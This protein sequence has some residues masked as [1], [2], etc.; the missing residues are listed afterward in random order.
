MVH[1]ITQGVRLSSLFPRARR[2]GSPDVLVSSC[3]SEAAHVRP[4][5]IYVALVRA[6]RDGHEEIS[7]AIRRGAVA[8]VVERPL[9]IGIPQYVVDDTREALG[10]ICQHL[11][12][13]PAQR[14]RTIGVSGTHGKTCVSLLL[15]SI[16]KATGVATGTSHS[17][18][19]SDSLRR[20]PTSLTTPPAPELARR[21]ADMEAA[22][23]VAAVL[24]VNSQALA[25]RR[26][27]SIGWDVAVLTNLRRAHLDWH[28]T[29][30][31]Y[32]RAKMR[33]FE[34]LKEDGTAV[35]NADDPASRFVRSE[36][37]CPVMTFGIREEADVSAMVIEQL[38][39][40]QTFLLSVG[41]HTA[42]VRTRIVGEHHVANCLAA[43]AG[44]LALGADL[45]SVV[46]GLEAVEHLPGRMER[47]ECGQP[48]GVFVDQA[49][50]PDRL[51]MALRTLRQVA[52]GR[53]LCV[54]GPQ[55]RGPREERPLLGRVVERTSDLGI[56]TA[57]D[58]Q[59]EPVLR[60]AHDVLDGYTRPGQAHII[61]DR[62]RAIQWAL[63]EARPGDCVLI[64]GK[65][66]SGTQ[67]LGDRILDW[68]DRKVAEQQLYAAGSEQPGA[69]GDSE[70]VILKLFR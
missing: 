31:N 42:A 63:S 69:D 61:P 10:R 26:V 66:D 8:A 43:A 18:G 68:S 39:S 5:D 59:L 36:L 53:V 28:G 47:L 11:V 7:E 54:Y 4:G 6:T 44:A 25:E 3:S 41:A 57:N 1:A 38:V 65:G 17:L 15:E 20:L 16:L 9:P 29:P 12:M 24:E 45:P 34:Q 2:L 52:A 14:L 51:A 32:R 37:A 46:R 35:I 19:W 58:P 67:D 13:S 70:P 50:N 27:A 62:G 33:L 30:A 60:I 56:I 55:G 48:F 23:C 21:L 40:E 22:G 64:A 49:D